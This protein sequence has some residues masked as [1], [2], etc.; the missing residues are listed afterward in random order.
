VSVSYLVNDTTLTVVVEDQGAGIQVDDR[1]EAAPAHP[2]EGGMG[3]S[4]MR[5]IVDELQVGVGA[6]GRGT[7]VQMTKSLEQVGTGP[8]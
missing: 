8:R 6:D 7:V 2:P 4:L 1:P 5:A 3:M